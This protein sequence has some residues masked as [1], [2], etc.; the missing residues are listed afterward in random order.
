MPSHERLDLPACDVCG[1]FVPDPEAT[2]VTLAWL[3]SAGE[4]VADELELSPHPV[5][6]STCIAE[7]IVRLAT[8][9]A[10]RD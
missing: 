9:E 8:G 10:R 6:C 7:A 5:V 4:Q 1:G 2:R 3:G